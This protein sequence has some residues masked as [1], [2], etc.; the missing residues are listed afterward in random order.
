LEKIG[1]K[2]QTFCLLDSADTK[3]CLPDLAYTTYYL[4][5]WADTRLSAR[6]GRN[7]RLS[8][9]FCTHDR[10][11]FR[12]VR[13]LRLSAR[14]GKHHRL[15]VRSRRNPCVPKIWQTASQTNFA[16]TT[17]KGE[18]RTPAPPHIENHGISVRHGSTI[19]EP[20]K[21]KKNYFY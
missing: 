18:A 9:R 17:E 8:V 13:N 11:S 7:L 1:Q 16:D 14:F 2:F 3:D 12:S 19:E 10:V 15:S 21:K 6:C 4:L 20:N 5:G